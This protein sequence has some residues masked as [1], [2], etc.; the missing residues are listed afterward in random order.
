MILARAY[1]PGVGKLEAR[2]VIDETLVAAISLC[3]WMFED[4]QQRSGTAEPYH[5]SRP[6][7]HT[8]LV[9]ILAAGLGIAGATRH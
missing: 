7:P 3:S 2:L 5:A 9:E 1:T 4:T 6:A 8:A